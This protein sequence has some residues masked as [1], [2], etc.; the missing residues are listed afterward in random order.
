MNFFK[1]LFGS[2]RT[3]ELPVANEEVARPEIKREDFV[4]DSE[5][6]KESNIVTITFGTG[7]PIDAI[8]TFIGRD[9]EQ[10]GYDDAMINLDNSY[11]ESKK[12]IILNELKI[13]IEQVKLAYNNKLREIEVSISNIEQQGLINTSAQLKAK[14]QTYLE[15]IDKI[16]EIESSINLGDKKFL[17]MIDSYERGFLKG[18]AAKTIKFFDIENN[19]QEQN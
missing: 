5:P 15:H 11:K 18:V 1:K 14:R 3:E 9:Y 13:R 4:D 19:S 10:E 16:K 6:T 17:T 8:Y 12:E 7:L 2:N